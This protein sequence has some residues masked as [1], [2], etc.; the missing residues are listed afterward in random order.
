MDY[1]KGFGR[2][3]THVVIT[4]THLEADFIEDFLNEFYAHSKHEVRQS[5][6]AQKMFRVI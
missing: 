2:D 4:I 3:E 5:H 6:H 1:T